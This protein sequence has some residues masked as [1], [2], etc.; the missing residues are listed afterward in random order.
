MVHNVPATKHSD[1]CYRL[2]RKCDGISPKCSLCKKTQI[3]CTYSRRYIST[4]AP[5]RPAKKD[6]DG[7][8]TKALKKRVN[9]LEGT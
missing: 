6:D 9:E 4:S 3:E 7:K 8:Q 1:N 2:H 5:K